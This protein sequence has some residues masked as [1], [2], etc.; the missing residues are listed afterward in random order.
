MST[1]ARK[2]VCRFCKGGVSNRVLQ[3]R[4]YN[5]DSHEGFGNKSETKRTHR[6]ENLCHPYLINQGALL[7]VRLNYYCL[8]NV[9]P[10]YAL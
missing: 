6:S 2:I 5:W 8:M 9:R 4:K 3:L 7:F 10:D 1:D